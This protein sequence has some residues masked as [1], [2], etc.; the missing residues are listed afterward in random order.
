MKISEAL[1]GAM[2]KYVRLKSD[3]SC[4]EVLSYDE[5]SYRNYGCD[6]CGPEYIYSVDIYYKTPNTRSGRANYTYEGKFGDLIQ[7]LD[8]LSD[9]E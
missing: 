7:A 4:T 2:A 6:T 5:N 1:Y 3:A 9:E 8:D